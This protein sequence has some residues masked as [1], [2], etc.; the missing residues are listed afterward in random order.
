MSNY[1]KKILK[2]RGQIQITKGVFGKNGDQ[3]LTQPHKPV[4]S[5]MFESRDT[6]NWVV[7]R[8]GYWDNS[9]QM[10]DSSATSICYYYGIDYPSGTM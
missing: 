10:I 8:N 4:D 2:Q 1:L 9:L 5:L 3:P 6:K 7:K